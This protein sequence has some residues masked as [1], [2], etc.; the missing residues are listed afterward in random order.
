[1]NTVEEVREIKEME[2]MIKKFAKR[3]MKYYLEKVLETDDY[4][5]LIYPVRE[6]HKLLKKLESAIRSDEVQIVRNTGS[7]KM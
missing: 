4:H 7:Y 1:M 3:R 2:N 6:Y 5:N